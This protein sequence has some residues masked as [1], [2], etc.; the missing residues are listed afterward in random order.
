[1][2]GR[3]H[4]RV[5]RQEHIV[6]IGIVSNVYQIQVSTTCASL[7]RTPASQY[8]YS[9]LARDVQI[10]THTFILCPSFQSAM[11]EAM[12]QTNFPTASPEQSEATLLRYVRNADGFTFLHLN[13]P[14]VQKLIDAGIVEGKTTPPEDTPR[15]SSVMI[16]KLARFDTNTLSE[17]TKLFS[18]IDTWHSP[19]KFTKELR[20]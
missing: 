11:L 5:N 20:E 8:S 14:A 19:F 17:L 18:E 12:M 16:P 2:V 6:D 9:F 10:G 7:G 15:H 1:M 4:G 3:W 13:C